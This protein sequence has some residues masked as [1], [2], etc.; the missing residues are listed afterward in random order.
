MVTKVATDA[1]SATTQEK[2][3]QK[4]Q[5]FESNL[6]KSSSNMDAKCCRQWQKNVEQFWQLNTAPCSC[7]SVLQVW[8]VWVAPLHLVS[9]TL[10]VRLDWTVETR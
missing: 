10:N 9:W 8:R 4:W 2:Y 1:M 3:F 5:T 6:D 7:Y